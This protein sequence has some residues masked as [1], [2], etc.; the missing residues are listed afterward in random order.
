MDPDFCH[1]YGITRIECKLYRSNYRC[2][3]DF[4]ADGAYYGSRTLCRTERLR[5]DETLFKEL[6]HNDR[7]QCDDG[8][9]LLPSCPY[10]R[11]TVRAAGTYIA[12]YL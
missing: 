11:F 2:H 3:V 10:C 6:S 7:F 12:H 9:Y 4:S 1:L 8:H 5:I